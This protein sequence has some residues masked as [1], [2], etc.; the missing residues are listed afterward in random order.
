[1]TA[2]WK[3]RI[4]AGFPPH[5]LTSCTFFAVILARVHFFVTFI[6]LSEKVK[7]AY[8]STLAWQIPW[9]EEPGR[10]QSIGSLRVGHD[11]AISLLLFT[12]MHWR[13]KRV[14]AWRIPGTAEPGGLPSMGLQ[15]RTRLKRLSSYTFIWWSVIFYVADVI[16]LVVFFGDKYFLM[17]VNPFFFFFLDSGCCC[18]CC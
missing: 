7:A 12:F 16:A 17:R 8:S 10:L 15:S 14:L 5:L 6:P 13:R 9:T 11:W 3:E 2:A 1:M 18:C 4:A